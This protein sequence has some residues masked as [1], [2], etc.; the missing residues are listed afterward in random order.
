MQQKAS[1]DIQINSL[2]RLQK[3]INDMQSFRLLAHQGGIQIRCKEHS[4]IDPTHPAI[5]LRQM[6]RQIQ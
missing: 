3:L 2:Y 1:D 5:L 4:S 6:Q